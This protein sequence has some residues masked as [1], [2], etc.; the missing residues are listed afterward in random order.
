MII[1]EATLRRLHTWLTETVQP[2]GAVSSH[3]GH[4]SLDPS[5]WRVSVAP[6]PPSGNGIGRAVLIFD[7]PEDRKYKYDDD[8]G[9]I[10]TITE[11]EWAE[12]TE[13]VGSVF[14]VADFWN[15]VG[16]VTGSFGVN[17]D[18]HVSLH[19]AVRL[20]RTGCLECHP[21]REWGT[22]FCKD[23]NHEWRQGFAL[24]LKPTESEQP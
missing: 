19:A 24:L 11:A 16:C 15:G 12:I 13:V 18:P 9:H 23:V 5:G 17:N 10:G 20:Y 6:V 7:V 1:S 14:A 22:P 3:H 2:K 21:E 4:S 8:D